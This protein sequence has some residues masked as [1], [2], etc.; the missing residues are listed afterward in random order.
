MLTTKLT[1]L[2]SAALSSQGI[3]ES[4]VNISDELRV[5][6]GGQCSQTNV[7]HGSQLTTV[8]YYN[9]A[10]VIKVIRNGIKIHL[11]GIWI[12]RNVRNNVLSMTRHPTYNNWG[13]TECIL[14]TLSLDS[15]STC[16]YWIEQSSTTI[17]WATWGNTLA[18]KLYIELDCDLTFSIGVMLNN[19]EAL[20][21][22]VIEKTR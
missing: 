20:Q 4:K 9:V 1:P 7:C 11:N 6:A 8:L 19:E 18:Q 12:P 13:S 17:S 21:P 10:S 15:E 2:L 14:D 3:R 22:A 5:V 16:W